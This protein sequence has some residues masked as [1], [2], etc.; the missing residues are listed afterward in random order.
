MSRFM[1]EP[2]LGVGERDHYPDPQHSSTALWRF[3]IA[4]R[5]AASG[6]FVTPFVNEKL[7]WDFRLPLVSSINASGHKVRV[8]L[9]LFS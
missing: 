7:V 3:I 8:S 5:D 4:H 6:G 1:C 2:F 9:C